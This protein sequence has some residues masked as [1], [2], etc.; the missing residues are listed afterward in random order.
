MKIKKINEVNNLTVQVPMFV[1]KVKNKE[2]YFN[3]VHPNPPLSNASYGIFSL[4][5]EIFAS[6]SDAKETLEYY[7][8]GFD[9]TW[10]AKNYFDDSTVEDFVIKKIKLI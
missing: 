5:P 1:I 9:G 6:R 3:R 2:I 7:K 8:S 10:M 4:I